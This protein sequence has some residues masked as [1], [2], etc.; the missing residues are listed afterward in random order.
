MKDALY[1][2]IIDDN[3]FVLSKGDSDVEFK[4][5]YYFDTSFFINGTARVWNRCSSGRFAELYK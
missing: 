5:P 1:D 4:N 3:N 2:G